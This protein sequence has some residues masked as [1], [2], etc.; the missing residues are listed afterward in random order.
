MNDEME[1]AGLE[2]TVTQDGVIKVV[3]LAGTLSSATSKTFKE[4]VREMIEKER[5]PR[6]VLG[7]AKVEFI[8]SAGWGMIIDATNDCKKK[9]G[10]LAIAEMPDKVGRLY[11]LMGV[12]SFLKKYATVKEAVRA[13]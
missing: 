9:Q 2:I 8:S 13:L 1:E 7:M 5:V 4:K 12:D 11:K 3:A 6:V 10:D